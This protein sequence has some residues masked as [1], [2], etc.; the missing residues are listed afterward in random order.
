MYSIVYGTQGQPALKLET[1]NG[2]FVTMPLNKNSIANL[3]TMLEAVEVNIE[4]NLSLER[5]E[6]QR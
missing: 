6:K 3:I 5:S 1:D 2:L 4:R